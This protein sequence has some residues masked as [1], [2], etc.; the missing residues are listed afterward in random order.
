MCCDGTEGVERD[1]DVDLV[2]AYK[3]PLMAGNTETP[4]SNLSL[5]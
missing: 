5:F 3:S 1:R 4:L 2:A